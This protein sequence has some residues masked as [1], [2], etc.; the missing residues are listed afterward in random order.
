VAV[1]AIPENPNTPAIMAIIKNVTAQLI[2]TNSLVINYSVNKS[3][4]LKSILIFDI[5]R[6]ALIFYRYFKYHNQCL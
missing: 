2:M 6:S 4:S 1:P 3:F 5:A